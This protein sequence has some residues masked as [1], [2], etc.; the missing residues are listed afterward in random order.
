MVHRCPHGRE[1]SGPK[2]LPP[3]AWGRPCQR[4]PSS[5]ASSAGR[6]LYPETDYYKPRRRPECIDGPRPCPYVS[7]KHHLYLDVSARTGAI[8]LNFPDLEPDELAESCALDI[9]DR[10]GTALEEVGA[11]L[12]LT[13]ERVR[14][15]EVKALGKPG[16][17]E[18]LRDFAPDGPTRRVRR[19]P[20][21]EEEDDE[22]G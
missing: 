22:E 21:I 14:Q 1:C 8:K 19:L 12:N 5:P 15:I 4:C 18:R 9:A 13:R 20:V 7:C 16:V 10:G 3:E 6:L 11:I 17:R 2:H